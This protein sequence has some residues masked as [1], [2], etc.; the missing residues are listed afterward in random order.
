MPL[1][2]VIADDPACQEHAV[3]ALMYGLAEKRFGFCG[4]ESAACKMSEATDGF[5]DCAEC[6]V[7]DVKRNSLRPAG[8]RLRWNCPNESRE[9]KTS[10]RESKRF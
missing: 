4:C 1:R 8:R 9:Q 6:R 5:F 10:R 2:E 3:E 7:F